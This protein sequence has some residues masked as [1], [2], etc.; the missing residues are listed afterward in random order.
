MN[1]RPDIHT[2]PNVTDPTA[3]PSYAD[4]A[5]PDPMSS[6][7]E[8]WNGSGD[9]TLVD[10]LLDDDLVVDG[11]ITELGA[12][13]WADDPAALEGL[14][15]EEHLADCYVCIS[16][17][18]AARLTV[19]AT[20]QAIAAPITIDLD[21]KD[22]A[23]IRARNGTAT[24]SV[25]VLPTASAE[26]TPDT[27]L[28]GLVGSSPVT[29]LSGARAKKSSPFTTGRWLAAA[30]C[31]AGATFA[32]SRLINQRDSNQAQTNAALAASTTAPQ[33]TTA[34]E[35][36]QVAAAESPA[37]TSAAADTT[38]PAAADFAPETLPAADQSTPAESAVTGNAVSP[39]T[40]APQ[41]PIDAAVGDPATSRAARP[42]ATTIDKA[43][44]KEG[45]KRATKL[46]PITGPRSTVVP[47]TTVITVPVDGVSGGR[48]D[49]PS[50]VP[51]G[52][53]AAA[54]PAPGNQDR[55]VV[56]GSFQT[57][58]E[59]IA[60]V[61]RHPEAYDN[62]PAVHRCNVFIRS[63][64]GVNSSVE[65]HY[66]EITMLGTPVVVGIV[67]DPATASAP[68]SYR[69]AAVS[70]TCGAPGTAKSENGPATTLPS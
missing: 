25:T 23:I 16:N 46:P 34:L 64:L 37:E 59:V 49:T 13:V 53:I 69:I 33:S 32:G 63:V 67:R 60:V 35:P 57:L 52:A 12:L 38:A 68:V 6:N 30:A 4:I 51:P 54:P 2:D 40:A 14:V 45:A 3:I 9:V 22:A 11:H 42:P 8:P 48:A 19:S 65:V 62:L 31:V 39:E 5:A 27:T 58:D 28:R 66:A 15:D 10:E 43:A 56:E 41:P 50:T 55:A 17:I 7:A 26:S 61:T 29:S 24:A 20:T 18:E 36:A 21:T 47:P 70:P 1:D 44:P